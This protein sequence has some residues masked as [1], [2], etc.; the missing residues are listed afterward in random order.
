MSFLHEPIHT[1]CFD[2]NVCLSRIAMSD[3]KYKLVSCASVYDSLRHTMSAR[4]DF[5]HLGALAFS[6][7]ILGI[8]PSE[9]SD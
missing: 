7:Y 6:F 8:S 2:S 5:Q 3:E 4:A 9:E 1:W